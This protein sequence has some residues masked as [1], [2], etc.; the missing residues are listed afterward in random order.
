MVPSGLV[1]QNEQVDNDSMSFM[2]IGSA[3]SHDTGLG[4]K[5]SLRR[6]HDLIE[7]DCTKFDID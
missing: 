7:L 3:D 4:Q 1:R 5:F 6:M 2:Y